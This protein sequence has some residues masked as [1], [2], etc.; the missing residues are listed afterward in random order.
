MVIRQKGQ[1]LLQRFLTGLNRKD[2]IDQAVTPAQAIDTRPPIGGNMLLDLQIRREKELAS[3]S[4]PWSVFGDIVREYVPEGIESMV[5]SCSDRRYTAINKYGRMVAGDWTNKLLAKNSHSYAATIAELEQARSDLR[6]LANDPENQEYRNDY[7]P[8]V[9]L[10]NSAIGRLETDSHKKKERA[11][12][13]KKRKLLTAGAGMVAGGLISY[14]LSIGISYANASEVPALSIFPEGTGD[15]QAKGNINPQGL[16]PTAE[17]TPNPSQTV[18]PNASETPEAPMAKNALELFFGDFIR[19]AINARHQRASA[20][21]PEQ[22]DEFFARIGGK[23]KLDTPCL[24]GAFIGLDTGEPYEDTTKPVHD[25]VFGN[26]RE[27]NINGG[28]ADQ[29]QAFIICPSDKRIIQASLFRDA[30]APDIPMTADGKGGSTANMMAYVKAYHPYNNGNPDEPDYHDPDLTRTVLEHAFGVP[31]DFIIRG[32]FDSFVEAFDKLFPARL[33]V[34]LTP[35]E[36]FARLVDTK[37]QEDFPPGVPIDFDGEKALRY[38][39]TRQL[40][41]SYLDCS[42]AGESALSRENAFKTFFRW[43]FRQ[44]VKELVSL[45]YQSRF[46]EMMNNL[47]DV[48]RMLESDQRQDLRLYSDITINGEKLTLSDFLYFYHQ[49]INKYTSGIFTDTNKI[50]QFLKLIGQLEG[51]TFTGVSLAPGDL[52]ALNP[53]YA[54]MNAEGTGP[55]NFQDP[56][57]ENVLE[58][59]ARMRKHVADALAGNYVAPD[60]CATPIQEGQQNNDDSDQSNLPDP[61]SD[62]R[63]THTAPIAASLF[64]A[65]ISLADALELRR[66][67]PSRGKRPENNWVAQTAEEISYRRQL[68]AHLESILAGPRDGDF[69]EA[70]KK[71]DRMKWWKRKD[72]VNTIEQ[73]IFQELFLAVGLDASG[74]P[75]L[76]HLPICREAVSHVKARKAQERTMIRQ[77]N[78]AMISPGRVDFPNLPPEKT[79]LMSI[80]VKEKDRLPSLAKALR[81]FYQTDE[82]IEAR[83]VFQYPTQ[84]IQPVTETNT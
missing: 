11:P 40:S 56:S 54:L 61:Q 76:S 4:K 30:R 2:P 18:T 43:G 80:A 72:R 71:L 16:L 70:V 82:P 41:Q 44:K 6:T 10:A 39:R 37:F 49:A 59:W 50:G 8:L 77:V 78:D 84:M 68:M 51:V 13:T 34:T 1:S 81:A 53:K 52:V 36:S 63:A 45:D 74:D 65:S 42:G 28:L 75:R 9:R 79:I 73:R 32:N 17:A 5:D 14:A 7:L 3:K 62:S 21:T 83:V 22:R 23:E 25:E 57:P 20:L 60:P 26:R 15:D 55:G 24:V 69:Y 27:G 48:V 19:V 31:I 58:Y 12:W 29:V 64:S 67:F 46:D 66:K 47:I 35:E 38:I 33:T